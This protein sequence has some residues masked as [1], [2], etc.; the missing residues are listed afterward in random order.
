[1]RDDNAP[2]PYQAAGAGTPVG[3]YQQQP[4]QPQQYQ[5][6]EL[7]PYQ[8]QQQQQQQQ[9]QQQPQQPQPPHQQQ[10]QYQQQQQQQQNESA[11][12]LS[13]GSTEVM[14]EDGQDGDD[15]GDVQLQANTY[16]EERGYCCGMCAR[17]PHVLPFILN[18]LVWVTVIALLFRLAFQ[19][20]GDYAWNPFHYFSE[21]VLSGYLNLYVVAGVASFFFLVYMVG[22]L[23]SST[24][25]YI[26]SIRDA[27]SIT[28]HV[29]QVKG[30]VPSLYW[31]CQSYHF[32]TRHRHVSESYR[33]SNG[34]QQTRMKTETYQ[35]KVITHSDEESFNYQTVV[36]DSGLLT[37]DLFK[38]NLT[39]VH[40]EK[41]WT[42]G[43][44]HTKEEYNH[45]H[46]HFISRNRCRD[47]HFQH[48]THFKIPGFQKK[49]LAVVD[50]SKIPVAMSYVVYLLFGVLLLHFPYC[51]W[52]ERQTAL[53][54]FAF[55][56]TLFV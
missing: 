9:Y 56:K 33:D 8:Q 43:N 51:M 49:M 44:P 42:L 21:D 48:F 16:H 12:L 15:D 28:N 20:I 26:I 17:N 52:F 29:E 6:Q 4:Q 31:T 7:S 54:R 5:Q 23:V 22:V 24:G 35:E 32:E 40:F 19:F 1:M 18:A 14:V 41:H 30:G 11:P 47:T 39:Q 25:R 50:P 34:N 53:G 55:R 46:G 27:G 3:V 38:N 10:Q 45:H 37:T 36:D 13:D 2:P